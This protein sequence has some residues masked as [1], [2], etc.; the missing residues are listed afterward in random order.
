MSLG[1]KVKVETCI[2]NAPNTQKV[3]DVCS[4]EMK[5]LKGFAIFGI[6]SK[7]SIKPK[8]WKYMI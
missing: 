1:E 7:R 5:E 8:V 2:V 4:L 3:Y 6:L